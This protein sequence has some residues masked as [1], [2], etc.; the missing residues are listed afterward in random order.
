M[1]GSIR[2]F[3]FLLFISFSLQAEPVFQFH[4]LDKRHGL[5][6]SVVYD[7]AEDSDGFVWF[8]TEDGLQKIG[9]A[10]V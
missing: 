2:F 4:A 6:S 3:L 9:R 1:C 7:I 8:A 10:H 5:A